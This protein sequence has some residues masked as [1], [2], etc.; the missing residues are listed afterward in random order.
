[1]GVVSVLLL[2]QRLLLVNL[3]PVWVLVV[4][5]RHYDRPVLLLCQQ[6]DDSRNSDA[7]MLPLCC[8][9]VASAVPSW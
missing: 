4:F 8:T 5:R 7:T 1:M 6:A 3:P 2:L 9:L